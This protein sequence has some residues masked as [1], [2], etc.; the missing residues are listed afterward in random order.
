MRVLMTNHDLSQIG[1]TQTWLETMAKEIRRRGHE[2]DVACFINGRFGDRL[3]NQDFEVMFLNAGGE[4]MKR[5]YG[6][7]IANHNTC[8]ALA[9][10]VD[11]PKVFTAHG[12][13]HQ[14]ER[15]V[16]G[17]DRYFAVSEEVQRMYHQPFHPEVARNPIDL[18]LYR[19]DKDRHQGRRV[20]VACKNKYAMKAAQTACSKAGFECEWMHYKEMPVGTPWEL[21][22]HFDIAI[23]SGRGAYEAIACGLDVII[24]DVR[25]GEMRADGWARPDNIEELV[26][27]NCSGRAVDMPWGTGHLVEALNEWQPNWPSLRPWV[28]EHHDVRK[29]ATRYLEVAA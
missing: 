8:L 24:F 27:C 12:P 25:S 20:I 29:T 16:P 23:T 4:W 6:L 18:I 2:V 19:P 13:A 14:L 1:G 5:D 11:A 9:Q 26:K 3:R 21:L 17:A 28:E 10:V 7:V 22:P 15:M